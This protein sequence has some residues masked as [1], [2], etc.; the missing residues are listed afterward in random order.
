MDNITS[1]KYE[2]YLKALNIKSSEI[3]TRMLIYKYRCSLSDY[4]FNTFYDIDDLKLIVDAFLFFSEFELPNCIERQKEML[5]NVYERYKDVRSNDINLD[6]ISNAEMISIYSFMINKR[7]LDLVETTEELLSLR[8]V[9]SKL[10]YMAV[11][12]DEYE[13]EHGDLKI[14]LK[15][16]KKE[17]DK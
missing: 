17:N 2:L 14:L 4:Y 16:M 13:K 11:P 3:D 6:D 9:L 1:E 10:L 8:P 15:E 12:I 5:D 7:I